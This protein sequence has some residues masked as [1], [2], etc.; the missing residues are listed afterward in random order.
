MNN[1][2]SAETKDVHVP[3]CMLKEWL[4]GLNDSL[5]PSTYY[6]ICV[7]MAKEKQKL[8]HKTLDC[9][10]MLRGVNGQKKK[11]LEE[12]RESIRYLVSFLKKMLQ[13][14]HVELTKMNLENLSIVFAPTILKCP[15][16][17][18]TVLIQNNKFEKD[19]ILQ[20]ITNLNV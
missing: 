2:Y 19:F 5:I 4:R 17:D 20:M 6:E 18:P 7:S 13:P 15:S 10:K 16:D 12:N 1:D 11:K 9:D 14:E 3:A 8:D